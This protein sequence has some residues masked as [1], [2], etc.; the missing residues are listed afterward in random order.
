[1]QPPKL[2]FQQRSSLAAHLFKALVKQHNTGWRP[3]F[4]IMITEDGVVFDVGAHNGHYTKQFARAA[5]RGQVYAFEPSSLTR[6]IVERVVRWHRLRNVEVVPL[7][8]SDAPGEAVLSTPIKKSGAHG[9]GLAR[10]GDMDAEQPAAAQTIAVDTIDRFC[11]ARGIARLDFVKM[12]IEGYEARALVGARD[13]LR[14]FRPTM[15]VEVLEAHLAHAGSTSADLWSVI[16]PIGYA[17]YR[18]SGDTGLEPCNG[19]VGPGDYLFTCTP[20]RVGGFVLSD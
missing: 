10:L 9:I 2:T 18:I 16:G 5:R 17:S 1:M 6:P 12:D 15:I 19:Y 4:E 7:A 13:T 8:L 20:E 3:F 11:A 14:R